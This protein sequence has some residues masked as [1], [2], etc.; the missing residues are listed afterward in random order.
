MIRQKADQADIVQLQ[1][2]KTNKG[3]T[4]LIMG[5]LGVIKKLINNIAVLQT[6]QLRQGLQSN[7]KHRKQEQ[8]STLLS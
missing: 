7:S 3:D 4:E 6:E 5:S 2:C 8:I 1:Q